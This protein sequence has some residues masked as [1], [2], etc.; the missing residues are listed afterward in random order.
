MARLL[1]DPERRR[2]MGTQNYLA[3]CGLPM[4]EVVEWYLLHAQNVLSIRAARGQ[5]PREP[6]GLAHR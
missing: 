4:T 5:G 2:A 3:A 6:R 1:D